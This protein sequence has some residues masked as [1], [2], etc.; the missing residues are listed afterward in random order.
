MTNALDIPAGIDTT[1]SDPI[2]PILGVPTHPADYSRAAERID[3][4]IH[5]QSSRYVC[6]CPVHSIVLGWFNREH[7]RILRQSDLNTADGMPVVWTQQLL[8]SRQ[9]TRV[10]G[11]TL[12]QWLLHDAS[13]KGYRIG[14]YGGK[15]EAVERLVKNLKLVYPRMNIVLQISP[16][17]RELTREEDDEMT[18][19][20]NAARPDLLWIGLGC[21]RQ[22]R[23]MAEH[24]HRIPAVMIGVGAAFDFLSGTVRQA[25]RWM[26]N[27]G[28][29]WFYRL[30]CEPRRLWKRYLFTNS[31]FLAG[32]TLHLGLCGCRGAVQ[33]LRGL[34]G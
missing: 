7:R 27:S 10:Y 12:M 22:E 24:R 30:I 33:R 14:F 4:W 16:P 18:A 31:A 13:E 9:A 3:G 15:P 20:I 6:V 34:A 21:P 28:L 32:L 26:Q 5:E 11:P 1:T 8:G 23:W 17:Y 19:R 2:V 29:E 25:P